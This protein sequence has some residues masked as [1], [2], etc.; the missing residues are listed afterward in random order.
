MEN[1]IKKIEIENFLNNY[2]Y[3][4]EFENDINIIIGKNGCGKTTILEMLVNLKK[5]NLDYFFGIPFSNFLVELNNGIKYFVNKN[6]EEIKV[7]RIKN[8]REKEVI[9]SL[10]KED[11]QIKNDFEG[12][13]EISKYKYWRHAE[14][15]H[16]LI[17][18][19]KF[20][21]EEVERKNIEEL[22]VDLIPLTRA[23]DFFYENDGEKL[24]LGKLFE[25][26]KN[27]HIKAME[28]YSKE[29]EKFK[30]NVMML[31]FYNDLNSTSILNKVSETINFSSIKAKKILEIYE[32]VVEKNKREI[33][34]D[35]VERILEARKKLLEMFPK[36]S[37]MTNE[38]S[39]TEYISKHESKF[40]VYD[41][42]LNIPNTYLIKSIGDSATEL[43]NKKVKIFEKY[44]KI[45]EILNLFFSSGN[46]K[47]VIDKKGELKIIYRYRII[48]IEKL[49]SG[50]KQLITLFTYLILKSYE[51]S[52]Q[53]F[54][55]D[56]PELSLHLNWQQKFVD[57][58]Q[59]IN[60]KNQYIIATHSPEI[61]G[62][63]FKKVKII[64][65]ED[66]YSG[67]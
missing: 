35:E 13:E 11:I 53:I 49:S 37:K 57:A 26:I 2:N 3:K 45:E 66:E 47:V 27:D 34:R 7:I 33:V 48:D 43:L 4:I 1:K 44:R 15:N 16:K 18:W 12:K 10:K 55:I 39:K 25:S 8:N 21:N 60:G 32:E 9:K 19:D 28:N 24:K 50:E 38:I 14:Y 36:F 42:V 65:E 22:K 46:K 56:E 29:N 17:K 20:Y 41:I 59:K 54:M 63:Y 52:D 5:L 30:E 31:P 64:G 40:E 62:K 67:Y 51:N 23:H 61:I 58:L 6:R